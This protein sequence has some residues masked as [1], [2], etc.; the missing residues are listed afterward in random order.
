MAERLKTKPQSR[1]TEYSPDLILEVESVAGDSDSGR[2]M[3]IISSES[4]TEEVYEPEMY[5]DDAEEG[6]ESESESEPEQHL[7]D[8]SEFTTPDRPLK[9]TVKLLLDWCQ[10]NNIDVDLKT[11]KPAALDQILC[12]FYVEVRSK[13]GQ[14][15]SRNTIVAIRYGL[16]RYF[17]NMVPPRKMDII[18]ERAF[19]Y[20]N[21]VFKRVVKSAARE[22]PERTSPRMTTE[23][24]RKIYNSDAL[25]PKTPLTLLLK[26]WFEISVYFSR[27]RSKVQRDTK[28]TDFIFDIDSDGRRYATRA[29]TDEEHDRC[30]MYEKKGDEMC[31]ILSLEKLLTKID[32]NCQ[33]LFQRPR[34]SIPDKTS[35]WYHP[36]R[37]GRN[38][39]SQMMGKITKLAELDVKYTNVSMKKLAPWSLEELVF[40]HRYQVMSVQKSQAL[41]SYNSSC[42]ERPGTVPADGPLPPT[43]LPAD[44]TKSVGCNTEEERGAFRPYVKRKSQT[45]QDREGQHILGGPD[46]I[47]VNTAKA[48]IKRVFQRLVYSDLVTVVDWLKRIDVLKD[49]SGIVFCR[50][51]SYRIMEQ[52]LRARKFTPRQV[53]PP[54]PS[55]SA[56]QPYILP[57][58]L[59]LSQY[60]MNNAIN[61]AAPTAPRPA[62]IFFPQFPFT[63]Q[64]QAAN[65]L[66]SQEPSLPRHTATLVNAS[67]TAQPTNEDHLKYQAG[68]GSSTRIGKQLAI[69]PRPSVTA[70]TPGHSL[71]H[72]TQQQTAN[73]STTPTSYSQVAQVGNCVLYGGQLQVNID[74]SDNTASTTS[75][76]K[77][78]KIS[79]VTGESKVWK[80]L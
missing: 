22:N 26:V 25:S 4:V 15:Y 12:R 37:I 76:Q 56:I 9:F 27:K 77:K 42:T 36:E 18:E 51:N 45:K 57:S 6:G 40:Q 63:S 48:K 13:T 41:V 60:Y 16:N 33:Y 38:F 1:V 44:S 10:K 20:S 30:R 58:P 75:P 47:D 78:L 7:V 24:L 80:I 59:S 8:T 28:T 68:S 35:A 70:I 52:P 74:A 55:Q 23:D 43:V 67:V 53:H 50:E 54:Q 17:A 61:T 31:P 32:P 65:S 49:T 5:Y 3:D 14:R 21:V 29:S 11:I 2:H 73:D 34:L 46:P 64:S 69:A 72:C 19:R 39:T 71:G 79:N 62:A 66:A